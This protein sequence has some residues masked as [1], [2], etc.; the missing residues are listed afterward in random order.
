MRFLLVLAVLAIQGC[1][2]I[3][4]NFSPLASKIAATEHTT[5]L[6]MYKNAH[7]KRVKIPALYKVSGIDKENIAA[8]DAERR[9]LR[10]IISKLQDANIEKNKGIS[11][12]VRVIELLEVENKINSRLAQKSLKALDSEETKGM[13][14]DYM[15]KGMSIVNILMLI[16]V[17]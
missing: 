13:V 16:G 1:A 9:D 10:K 2:T 3:P 5:D 4:G 6:S 12:L 11:E 8:M 17:L 15:L 14:N 7:T